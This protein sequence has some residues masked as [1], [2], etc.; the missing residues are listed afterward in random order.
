VINEESPADSRSGMDLDSC[1]PSIEVRDQTGNS[2]P[3]PLIEEMGNS[4]QP[5]GVEPWIT[6]KD[7]QVVFC[8]WVSLFYRSDIFF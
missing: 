5:D 3:S 2:M 8:C 1:K 7:L 4:V 6:E